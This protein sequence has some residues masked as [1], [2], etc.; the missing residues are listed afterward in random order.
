MIHR[1]N[2]VAAIDLASSRFRKQGSEEKKVVLI[3]EKNIAVA[4]VRKQSRQLACRS[5][6]RKTGAD[7]NEGFAVCAPLIPPDLRA[8]GES[9]ASQIAKRDTA[10]RIGQLL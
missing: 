6:S 10:S 9:F 7:N 8:V 2:D 1:V 5:K 3:N 4:R